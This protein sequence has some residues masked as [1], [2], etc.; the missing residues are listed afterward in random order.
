[1]PADLHAPFAALRELLRAQAAGLVLRTD[2][3]DCYYL[4]TDHVMPNGQPLFFGS[5]QIK[6][7][8]VSYYLMPVYVR[9]A[10]LEGISPGLRQRMQGKSCFNFK[11]VEPELFGELA[12]LTAA[13]LQSYREQGHV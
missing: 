5:A 2:T 4:D 6:K 7:H 8:Y 1:M 9:P 13:G 3:P 12:Q 11:R 10:L